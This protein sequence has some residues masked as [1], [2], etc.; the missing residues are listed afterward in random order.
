M[1]AY[2]A[3]YYW[4]CMTV[5]TIGYGDIVGAA[6]TNRPQQYPPLPGLPRPRHVPRATHC[7]DNPSRYKRYRHSLPPPPRRRRS[8]SRPSPPCAHGVWQQCVAP[9]FPDPDPD[10]LPVRCT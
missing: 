9:L 10:P 4:S 5:T 1:A 3:A 2:T 8:L 7:V 6:R